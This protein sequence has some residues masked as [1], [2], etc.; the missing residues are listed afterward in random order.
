[1]DPLSEFVILIKALQREIERMMNDAM[2]P[3]GLTAQQADALHVIGRAGPLSL[4]ELGALLI[5]E[6][7]NPSRLVD[8]LVKAGY[9]QRCEAGTDRRRVELSLTAQ[10]EA[11]AERVAGARAEVRR[12]GAELIGDLDLEPAL[13]VLREIGART[14]YAELIER[15]APLDG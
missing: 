7:G 11:L 1:M 14:S 3:V 15:R 4:G 5:A 12:I 8:R 13:A 6:S 9:V 10:G 2:H